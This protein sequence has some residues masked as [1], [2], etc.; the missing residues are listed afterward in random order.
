MV[1]GGVL[2]VRAVYC[3]VEL[4]DVIYLLLVFSVSL[5]QNHG[6]VSWIPGNPIFTPPPLYDWSL[7]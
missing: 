3:V 4:C 5:S 7:G 1:W 6:H 2:C